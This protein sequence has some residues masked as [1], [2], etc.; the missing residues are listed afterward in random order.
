MNDLLAAHRHTIDNR[1][2]IEASTLCGCCNCMQCFPPADIV[3]FVGLDFENFDKPDVAGLET[4]LC[5]LCGGEAVIGDRSGFP[6]DPP[7]LRQ[8]NEAWFQRTVIR[9]P[10]PKK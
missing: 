9:K 8:M 6:V 1:V 4:A 2:E 7:F 3:A 5:P 10:A